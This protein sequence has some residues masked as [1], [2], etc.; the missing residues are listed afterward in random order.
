MATKSKTDKF[1]TKHPGV[2]KKFSKS[3]R[4]PK[5]GRP[6]EGFAVT[7][8]SIED[9]K[10]VKSWL[11]VGWKS[12]DMTADKANDILLAIKRQMKTGESPKSIFERV[13]N[14]EPIEIDPIRHNEQRKNL[15]T[16]GEA[17][18]IFCEKWLNA[19]ARPDDE[20][21]R[22]KKHL[23]PRFGNTPLDK[24][25]S[26]DLETLKRDL[27]NEGL[28]PA[29][30]K[31]ILGL[32][33]RVY[34]KMIT[35]EYYDGRTPT[36][37]VQMPKVDNGRVRYLTHNEADQ[38]MAALKSRSPFWWRI[39]MISLHTGMRL[40]EIMALT[41]IDIDFQGKVIYVQRGKAG[42]RMVQMNDT[43][44]AI[45]QNAPVHPASSLVFPQRNGEQIQTQNSGKL[46]SRVV[47]KLNLN[48]EGTPDSQKVVFHTLRHT[49]A[50]WLVMAG[51]P[52]Y[53]VSKLLG[54]ASLDM[55]YRY[56]HLAPD[57]QKDAVNLLA[58][59]TNGK[60][61]GIADHLK[62]A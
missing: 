8:R 2:Y 29:S 53:T 56:A 7:V 24:I 20:K 40:G 23:Q 27:F 43:A 21:G 1:A 25:K 35:W 61:A 48:P 11:Y 18:E 33:R 14:G 54:H 26:L 42:S 49:F 37:S 6:D 10:Y 22:Y 34:N 60:A 31:H 13:K 19:L 50:S 44:R 36:A 4:N 28:S 57:V 58:T 17:W 46:F 9:G 47:K 15:I 52:L 32:I 5:D 3:R 55:T 41:R 59:L 30:V 51:I 39:A 12:N 16:F 38:L 45:L 62:V